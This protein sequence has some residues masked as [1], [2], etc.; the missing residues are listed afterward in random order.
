MVRSIIPKILKLKVLLIVS[1]VVW[2][3]SRIWELEQVLDRIHTVR[4]NHDAAWLEQNEGKQVLD[5]AFCAEFI[6]KKKFMIIL[7]KRFYKLSAC[8][9][10]CKHQYS[11]TV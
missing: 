7:S 11:T 3:T 8:S 2:K 4:I 9:F 6:E 1:A 10:L 5:I